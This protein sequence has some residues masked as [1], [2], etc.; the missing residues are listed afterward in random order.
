MEG[1]DKMRDK[2]IKENMKS[3]GLK[4]VLNYLD[5]DPDSNIPKIINW[6]EKFDKEGHISSQFNIVRKELENKEGNWYKLAESFWTD[7]DGEVRK[8]LF[9]NFIINTNLL[10]ANKKET[11][12]KEHNCNVP[13]AILMD[14]TSAC[15]LHC[16][17]CWAAEYGNKLN[18]SYETLDNIIS[19][20]KDMGTY[21]FIYSGGEPL[22][23]KNDI[24]KLCEKH[25]D[26]VFLSF[27]NGTLIDE[28][29]A[30]EILRV[31]NFVPA[32]SIEGFE[33]E[34]DY[35]RGNGTYQKVIQAMKILKDKKLPF[36]ISCC[37]TRKN[38]DII[39]SEEYFDAMIDKGAKFAWFFTYMP[40][41]KDAVPELMATAEQRKYMY[42]Q[43]R[44]F[45]NTKP[46]FT[47]DFWN[48]GEY[49]GGC[50]AGGRNYLH[51]NANGDIEPCAFIHYSDSSI[52][53]KTLLEAYKSPLFMEYHDN[54]PFNKNHLRPCPLL[55]NPNKLSEMVDKSGA[56]STDLQNPEDVHDLSAK[57]EEAAKDWALVADE[58]W[59][60]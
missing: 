59:N 25:D 24:I 26:C 22:V 37:Y 35:R 49:V 50:I 12:R 32:I 3:Y 4:I 44:K 1:G 8:K 47:M 5:S 11:I 2:T 39:G 28:E 10:G 41:G 40:V 45:R 16:T 9:E 58:I 48:D 42:H 19:Q 7:I 43:I 38:V 33:E 30:D 54:Q 55:D 57:C 51:I 52:Y 13:W 18:M 6:V 20:A 46:I 53:E 14:P 23:R 34:T 36:G 29:F 56:I 27:T 60:K 17:G 21:M 15:N 31:K